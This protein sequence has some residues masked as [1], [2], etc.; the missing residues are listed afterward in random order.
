MSFMW[1]VTRGNRRYLAC[2][3]FKP[4]DGELTLEQT[5]VK[6]KKKKN[7]KQVSSTG[8]RVWLKF[9]GCPSISHWR[10]NLNISPKS[11]RKVNIPQ[12]IFTCE[13]L[14]R[15][16]VIPFTKPDGAASLLTAP[17]NSVG[18][19]FCTGVLPADT[20]LN[21]P[22]TTLLLGH[23]SQINT[24]LISNSKWGL[25]QVSFCSASCHNAI[26]NELSDKL[27]KVIHC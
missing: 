19:G 12:H 26:K 3:F 14:Q 20:Y 5:A 22:M 17:P 18:A 24:D 15:P 13:A 8:E 27:H 11:E 23:S 21:E 7:Q 2:K 10:L 6:R 25:A 16:R 9:S 4:A 1:I